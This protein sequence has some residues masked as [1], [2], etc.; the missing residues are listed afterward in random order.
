MSN[1]NILKNPFLIKGHVYGFIIKNLLELP[2]L[3]IHLGQDQSVFEACKLGT[4]KMT[5]VKRALSKYVQD[6]NE[7]MSYN[8]SA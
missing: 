8:T 6:I 3:K 5:H 4:V 7:M 1:S 2:R